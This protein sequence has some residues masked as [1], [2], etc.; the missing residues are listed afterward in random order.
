CPFHG[1]VIPRDEFGRP[2][3]QTE[4]EMEPAEQQPNQHSERDSEGRGNAPGSNS[5]AT[6]EN[7]D[8]LRAEDI[9]KLVADKHQP[10]QAGRRK[11]Q[12]KDVAV[13]SSS[14]SPLVNI[15][16]KKPAGIKHLQ[17]LIKKYYK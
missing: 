6:A 5:V 15:H 3:G 13:D 9:E 2:Q 7:M 4:E 12:K 8:E 17:K 10:E 11:R 16:K 1:I 14:K